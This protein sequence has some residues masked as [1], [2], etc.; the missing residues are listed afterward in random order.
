MVGLMVGYLV[1]NIPHFLNF[2]GFCQH[3][4]AGEDRGDL[5]ETQRVAFDG[6]RCLNGFDPVAPPQDGT[7]NAVSS[8]PKAAP[9]C[10]M[11]CRMAGVM[12]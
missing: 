8:H 5:F 2:A 4:L 9:I 3:P 7:H 1:A 6:R 11:L 12:R 10:S